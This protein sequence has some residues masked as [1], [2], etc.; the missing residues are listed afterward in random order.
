MKSPLQLQLQVLISNDGEKAEN[1]GPVQGSRLGD[2][3][4]DVSKAKA[5]A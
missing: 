2:G 5:K 3:T 1:S 4:E